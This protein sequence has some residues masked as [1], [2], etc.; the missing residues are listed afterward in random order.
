MYLTGTEGDD[1]LVGGADDDTILG[2]GGDDVLI[3][4]GGHNLLDGGDGNDTVSYAD[5][6]PV[7]MF[8]FLMINL[9]SQSVSIIGPGG[10][11]VDTLVSIENA[12]GSSGA[13]W[14][15]GTSGDNH[16]SGGA[17]D[18]HIEGR[19]GADVLDGGDGNDNIVTGGIFGAAAPGSLMIGGAGADTIQSG[20]SNDTMLGGA[21]DDFLEVSNYATTRVIDGGTGTDTLAFAYS[22]APFLSGVVVDLGQ[23]SVQ[24][25]ASGVVLTLG[26]VENINGTDAADTLIGDAN[27]NR[28]SGGGGN[29]QLYGHDG[30]DTLLGGDGDDLIVGGTGIDQMTGGAG[31]DTFSFVSGDGPMDII[32]DFTSA[33]RIHFG[34]SPA[35]TTSNYVETTDMGVVSSLFAGEGVR[36][37]A[38][39]SGGNVMLFADLGDEGTSYDTVIVLQASNLSAIDYSSILGL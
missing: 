27:G 6:T 29:D 30:N 21:G 13:D 37:V 26:N 3:G 2:L 24:T 10:G 33:D 20:N 25:I 35:G 11:A 39:E 17:G 8:G 15:V 34:D 1:I 23:T 22:G 9:L 4:G 31:S 28:L 36:Y 38:V 19:G 16:L 14:L 7:G 12:I 32:T 18:D 5:A